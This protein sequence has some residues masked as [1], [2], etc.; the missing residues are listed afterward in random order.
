M[1]HGHTQ[2]IENKQTPKLNGRKRERGMATNSGES[3]KCREFRIK[4]DV[5]YNRNR[6][7]NKR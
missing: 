3:G 4:V 2:G 6:K 5:R 7:V 1:S